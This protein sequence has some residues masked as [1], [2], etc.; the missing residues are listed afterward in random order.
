MELIYVTSLVNKETNEKIY[1]MIDSETGRKYLSSDKDNYVP[2]YDEYLLE[3]LNKV[4][5]Y[6][7]KDSTAAKVVAICGVV[8]TLTVTAWGY[9]FARILADKKNE[10]YTLINSTSGHIVNKDID[11]DNLQECIEELS[12]S[13]SINS[14]YTATEAEVIKNGVSD[15]LSDW[16]YLYSNNDI[17]SLLYRIRSF[18]INRAAELDPLVLGNYSNGQINIQA[19]HNAILTTTHEVV[20]GLSNNTSIGEKKLYFGFGRGV[21]EAVTATINSHYFEPYVLSETEDSYEEPRKILF[22]LSLLINDPEDIIRSYFL[23]EGDIFDLVCENCPNISTDDIIRFFTMLDACTFVD[24]Q[25]RYHLGDDYEEE[26][27]QLYRKMYFDKYSKDLPEDIVF[28]SNDFLS[29]SVKY[30]TKSNPCIYEVP[31]E[32]FARMEDVRSTDHDFAIGYTASSLEY[33]Q[34]LLPEDVRDD[35]DDYKCIDFLYDKYYEI[36]LRQNN[37]DELNK[38]MRCLILDDDD[39]KPYFELYIDSLS[40][41]ELSKEEFES[42]LNKGIITFFKFCDKNNVQEESST[43]ESSTTDD[44]LVKRKYFSFIERHYAELETI[45]SERSIRFQND[46]NFESSLASNEEHKSDYGR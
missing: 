9:N 17:K 14:Y 22:R 36:G 37:M 31:R 45:M 24:G 27:D 10:G 19:G 28:L 5:E 41:K 13:I 20:H 1:I 44:D 38:F 40:S 25:E 16:G 46:L 39:F 43:I 8:G 3:Q 2:Y 42:E 23:N 30:Y 11:Y 29:N 18:K 4:E 6:N 21:R 35:L 12:K 32:M 26:M 33:L 7:M 34:L 15:F